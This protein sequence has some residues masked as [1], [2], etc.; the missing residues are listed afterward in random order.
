MCLNAINNDRFNN[1]NRFL[2]L[3]SQNDNKIIENDEYLLQKTLIF[4]F[5]LAM[6]YGLQPILAS[7]FT[8]RGISKPSVVVMTELGK[9]IIAFIGIASGIVKDIKFDD[10]NLK[11]SLAIAALPA[12]LY[13][14]QNVCVQYGYVYLDSMTFNVLNQ[15]K[16]LSA[17]VFC[18]L[19][20]GIKQSF[21][22][23]FALFLLLA[24]SV[25]LSMKKQLIVSAYD[26]N[27][28]RIGI[29]LVCFA[30]I[31]SGIS[32][33]LTQKALC[34]K[35]NRR[36]T[37][38]FS[39]E[40]AAWGILF[41]MVYDGNI[42]IKNGFFNEWTIKTFIPVVTNSLGGIIVG[43]VT[44]YGGSSV[45]GFALI[46]GLVITAIGHWFLEGISLTKL[47]F[48]AILLVS[49]SIYLHAKSPTIKRKSI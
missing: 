37:L 2:S 38:F 7:T 36:N 11:N 49:I 46:V 45:K 27:N 17:A 8:K 10:W 18:F 35:K 31:L 3:T 26:S 22:Q 34:D 40:L 23:I 48:L 30:S 24:A 16:T 4:S 47:D 29:I 41:L 43:L 32:T 42:I 21:L 5:L 1:N 39:A 15:T 25:M 28:Y 14:I 9:I 6:Q 44:K 20:L 33:A 19:L 12:A 13:A